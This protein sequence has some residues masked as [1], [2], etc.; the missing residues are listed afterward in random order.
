MSIISAQQNSGELWLAPRFSLTSPT[1]PD[2][3]D[4]LTADLSTVHGNWRE[5]GCIADDGLNLGIENEVEKIPCW[6]KGTGKVVIG[7]GDKTLNFEILNVEAF[8]L[9]FADSGI[10]TTTEPDPIGAPG[11]Y[12]YTFPAGGQEWAAIARFRDGQYTYMFVIG[13]GVN[14]K[15]IDMSVP[16]RGDV[17]RLPA[18]FAILTW[19]PDD[20]CLITDDPAFAPVTWL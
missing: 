2:V 7:P 3:G 19:E 1:L 20:V 12:K 9:Q 11:V 10:L 14:T 17:V 18:E 4:L 13:R 5:V 16:D 15:G 6:T 8:T